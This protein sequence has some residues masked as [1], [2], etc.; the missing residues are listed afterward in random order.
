MTSIYDIKIDSLENKP[1]NLS[2]YKNKFL[3]F[4]N[5]ASK[6]GLHLNI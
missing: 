6:Y 4:V 5:V 3:L 2:D 1:I